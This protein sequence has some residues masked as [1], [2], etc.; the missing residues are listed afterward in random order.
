MITLNGDN[1]ADYYYTTPPCPLF[2]TEA[3]A[4]EFLDYGDITTVGPTKWIR[5]P[6][7]YAIL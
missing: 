7:V 4:V 3:F 6:L 1:G 2:P 5:L